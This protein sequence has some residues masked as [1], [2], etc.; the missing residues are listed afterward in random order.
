ME[1]DNKDVTFVRMYFVNV[2]RDQ[3]HVLTNKVITEYF[4]TTEV[5]YDSFMSDVKY[6][7]VVQDHGYRMAI[8]MEDVYHPLC[9]PIKFIT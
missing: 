1:I 9:A 4:F 6:P 8:K 3:S 7:T 5:A 2:Y